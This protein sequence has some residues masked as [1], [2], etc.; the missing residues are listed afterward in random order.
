MSQA[1]DSRAG[2]AM[3]VDD[4]YRVE[5]VL[6]E[7]V[8][9]RTELVT[10]D[11]SGPYVRKRIPRGRARRMAWAALADCQSSRLPHVLASYEL[12]DSF[13]VV[14]DYVEGATLAEVVAERGRLPLGEAARTVRELCEAVTDLHVR[15]VAH[16]DVSPTNVVLAAD[17]AHLIDLGNARP[18]PFHEEGVERAFGTFGF[19][20]P[21]QQGANRVVTV[22]ERSDVYALGR[23]LG[24]LLTGVDPSTRA[25]ADALGDERLVP[26]AVRA[27]IR[28]ACAFEPSH[29]VATARELAD[30]VEAAE[31]GVPASSPTATPAAPEGEG[32][33]PSRLRL[34][35]R[36]ATILAL[37][38]TAC[39]LAA[40]WLL[41]TGAGR[42]GGDGSD[43]G[44]TD[45]ASDASWLSGAVS[46]AASDGDG[47]GEASSAPSAAASQAEE[48]LELVDTGYFVSPSGYIHYAFGIDNSSE[49][50]LYEYP[51]VLVTG[52]DEDGEVLFSD[53]MVSSVARP[54]ET[55]WCAAQGGNGNAP[56][57]VEF[58]L[59]TGDC[60]ASTVSPD[61]MPVY[62]SSVPREVSDGLGGTAFVGE[63]TLV[64][65]GI[66]LS[67]PAT[68]L[69]VVIVLRDASGAIVCGD[70]AFV[71]RPAEGA[72]V[73]YETLGGDVPEYAT[74]EAHVLPWF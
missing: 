1:G 37:A 61:E 58:Q 8:E 9:G 47:A 66:D 49:D 27:V 35:L 19:A 45:A 51:T 18:V 68:Q 56:A 52:R 14:L 62:E 57:E 71:T 11:G 54:G 64:R 67:A 17:G 46:G 3:G 20:A 73:S 60:V 50:T 34:L 16:C 43:A 28:D 33:T 44:G 69:M 25:Y 38:A 59:S 26:S 31:S 53:T 12:P 7:G 4:L 40:A 32:R 13:V 74:A 72:S 15:H 5:R 65:D 10:L 29:R 23:M 22:D 6:A 63:V 24:Y 36:P 41:V 21:E 2:H 39:A 48:D 55:S 42:A 70:S 30:A